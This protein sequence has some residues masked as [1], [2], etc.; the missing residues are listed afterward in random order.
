MFFFFYVVS[1]TPS[2]SFAIELAAAFV[3]VTGS[4][5][6][7]PLS[8]GQCAV[9]AILGVGL[10]EGKKTAI[11]WRMMFRTFAGWGITIFATGSLSAALFSFVTFAPSQIY[12]LSKHN[13]MTV[14]GQLL[15][16]TAGT[17][18]PTIGTDILG[19]VQLLVGYPADGTFASF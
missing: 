9:G 13:C 6:G 19:T 12:P 16:T 18:L 3:I 17:P 14:Y 5:L 4:F 1:I 11:N 15:N 7:L 2:R 10:V 8:S